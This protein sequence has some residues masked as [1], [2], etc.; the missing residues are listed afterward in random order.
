MLLRTV[1]AAAVMLVATGFTADAGQRYRSVEI[2]I[3]HDRCPTGAP[4][5]VVVTPDT[6]GQTP[7]EREYI[8]RTERDKAARRAE[9]CK[10][11][12]CAKE[13]PIRN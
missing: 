9:W 5:G 12:A 10:T 11:N 7:E 13:F 1:T 3:C 6:V 4:G 8:D 2:T